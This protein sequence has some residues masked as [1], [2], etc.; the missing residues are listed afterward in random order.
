[1]QIPCRLRRPWVGR[2]R[3]CDLPSEIRKPAE[4]QR[5]SGANPSVQLAAL[6]LPTAALASRHCLQAEALISQPE[7]RNLKPPTNAVPFSNFSIPYSSPNPETLNLTLSAVY[8][9]SPG[10]LFADP[11]WGCWLHRLRR[12]WRGWKLSGAPGMTFASG[13]GFAGL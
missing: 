10:T 11:A 8:I 13:L 5:R 7:P 6:S 4:P 2:L 9:K 1:M 12:L 3:V